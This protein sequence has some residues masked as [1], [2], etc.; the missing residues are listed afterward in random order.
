[1]A[2]RRAGWYTVESAGGICVSTRQPGIN[3]G[4]VYGLCGF[5]EEWICGAEGPG[6]VS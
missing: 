3:V 6:V 4:A 2:Q 1:M 5:E